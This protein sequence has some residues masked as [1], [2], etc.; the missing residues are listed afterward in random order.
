MYV[1]SQPKTFEILLQT[2]YFLS[3]SNLGNENPQSLGINFRELH[4]NQIV[5]LVGNYLNCLENGNG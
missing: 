4:G 2:H 5:F 1:L 3:G